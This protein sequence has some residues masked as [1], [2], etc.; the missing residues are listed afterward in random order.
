MFYI[1]NEIYYEIVDSQEQ[2]VYYKVKIVIIKRLTKIASTQYHLYH[3]NKTN[4]IM[5]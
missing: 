1:D 3:V 4:L 2:R 5:N